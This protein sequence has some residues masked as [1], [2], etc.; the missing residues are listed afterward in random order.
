MQRV[1]STSIETTHRHHRMTRY[2]QTTITP[3]ASHDAW[4]VHL[5]IDPHLLGGYNL[6]SQDTN[7][8]NL[9]LNHIAGL[10]VLFGIAP[11]T[12]A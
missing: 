9:G 12:Y 1:D 11:H 10:H 8:L 5:L 3:H 7:P 6:V 4:G 2:P